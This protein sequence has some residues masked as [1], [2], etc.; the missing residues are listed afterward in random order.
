MAQ[1]P[2][3]GLVLGGGGAKGAAEVG[4]L[5][6]LE[7][8][9][10][11]PDYICGTSIGSI[12]GGL[13]AAGYSAAELET[14]FQTQ[15]WLSLLTDRSSSLANEPYKVDND[16][17]YIFGFPIIDRKAKGLGVMKGSSIEH[18]LDSMVCAKGCKDF[19]SL[20]IPF[21]C[22]A[23]DIRSGTE[24]ILREGSLARAMRASMAIPAI[25]KPVE[26]D[27]RK[28]VDGGMLNN[29]PVDV[30][31]EMGADII[32]AVDLQQNEQKPRPQTDLSALPPIADLVGLG[33]ILNW[34]TNRPDIEKYNA[35]R[36]KVDIYIHPVLDA[37]V[38]SFG[39]K[40]AARM[41]QQGADAAHKLLPSLTKLK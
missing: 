33:G 15:E 8:A 20:K 11:K 32:I 23:A 24:V 10:I 31:R 39:N 6:V 38:T 14:M 9:G 21:C 3:I 28:L 1:G 22:V 18:M 13:Y 7:E 4:V 2:K 40:T 26:I 25:F 41:I 35:N 30:C 12:V 5:K 17:T 29:L 16:V 27:D 37:D 36:Q 34:I 19:Q